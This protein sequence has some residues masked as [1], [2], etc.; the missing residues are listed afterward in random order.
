MKKLITLLAL[1][2]CSDINA[3]VGTWTKLTNPAPE[4]N[5]GV[6]LLLS[7]GTVIAKTVHASNDTTEYGV[8][9]D[10]LTP[11]SLG[12]Y[13]NG[14]WSQIAPMNYSRLYFASQVLKDGRVFV[15]G[16]E[17]GTGTTKAE[18]YNPL[19]NTWTMAPATGQDFAD[20][21]SEIMNDGRVL[22]GNLG[23]S[24]KSTSFFNPT[25]NTW[26]SAPTCH[27]SHDESVWVKLPD[28][29]ILFVDFETTNSERYIPSL[30]QWVVDGIVPDSL[31]DP[32]WGESGAGFLLPDG[33][34]FFLGASGH[35]AYYTPTGNTTPGTWAAGPNIPTISGT[36]YGMVD[37]AAAM[38]VNGK[39][40]CTASPVNT[41]TTNSGSF[42]APTAFFEFDYL[43]NSFTQVGIPGGGA[44]TLNIPCFETNLL[45]LPDGTVLFSSQYDAQYYVYTPSG[46]PLAAGKPTIDTI[47]QTSCNTLRI[48]GTLFNGISE[49]A[50]Y[51]DDWQMA[52]NY[53]IIRLTNGTKVYYV[54]T[55]NWNST[56]VQTGNAADTAMFSIP[57]TL[58]YGT[59]S[60]V[61]TANGISSNPVTFINN[62]TVSCAPPDTLDAG[63]A[64]IVAPSGNYCE[65]TFTPTIILENF[66]TTTLTS[67]T[68]TYQI[69]G[70]ANIVYNW[71]G[72]LTLG[73]TTVTVPSMTTTSGT[74]TFTCYSS[75]PNGGMDEN[76]ANDTS[77]V[78]FTI[79]NSGILPIIEG[80]ETSTCPSGLLPNANWNISHSA[81]TGGVNFAITSAAAATGSKS[82][83]LNNMSNAAGD[84]SILQTSSYYDLTTLTT[85]SLT[86]KAAYQQKTTTNMDRLQ[87]LVSTDCGNSWLSKKVILGSTLALLAGGT[88]TSAYIPAS[89]QFT[90]YTVNVNSVASS[91]QVMFRWKFITDP[92]APGNNLYI[93]DINIVDAG[94]AGI[95]SIEAVV[96]DLNIYPNPNNGSFTIQPNS[97]TKQTMQVYDVNGKLVLSQTINGKT[98]IDAS[99]LNEGVYNISVI[100]DEG[101]INKR[102]VIVR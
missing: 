26:S 93:D 94:A 56:N 79:T 85:P 50:A 13:I 86:F 78:L 96:V 3:Q 22:V 54:R 44:G 31:Y 72:S 77:V 35:S 23:G 87:I 30:N 29:S 53:P 68:I 39:I 7:D 76:P 45:D 10:R 83:M 51:G 84:T 24:G 32:Y 41:S 67:C 63:I 9:W 19:T 2:F 20:A 15:A 95:Q 16:G 27:G 58:P 62:A 80:F 18:T 59:Y 97:V 71:S 92:S 33:R 38:M 70:G 98:T 66:A 37:A 52:T 8:I 28:N 21:N 43:A 64:S 34:A 14:T 82:C 100:S 42:L 88:G 101:V 75:S 90:T 99:I 36:Q 46:A 17:Y 60:L 91:H 55:F 57:S 61:V 47:V 40:L 73:Q 25:T 81:T 5:A 11:D 1:A 74:H 69:D 65:S 6:M 12:S 4:T 89:S 48:T 49:G 102:L